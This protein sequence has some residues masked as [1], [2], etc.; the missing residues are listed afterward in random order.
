MRG[1]DD[2]R[3]KKE[4]TAVP[5]GDIGGTKTNLAIFTAESGLLDSPEK[6]LR[7]SLPRKGL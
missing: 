3:T 7:I 1:S 4:A 2:Q 5:P 6:I